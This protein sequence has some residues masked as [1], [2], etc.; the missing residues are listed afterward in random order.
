[1]TNFKD[2][3]QW[4]QTTCMVKIKIKITTTW[5]INNSNNHY[6]KTKTNNTTKINR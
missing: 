4:F 1:M 2:I 6:S 5:V 3:K